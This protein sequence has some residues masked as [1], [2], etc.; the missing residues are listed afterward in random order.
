MALRQDFQ[1][2]LLRRHLESAL[3]FGLVSL[4]R[5]PGCANSLNFK[6]V[7][8]SDG[9]VFAV[10]CSDP[11]DV[12]RRKRLVAHLDELR[13]TKAVR[14]RLRFRFYRAMSDIVDGCGCLA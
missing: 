8:A 1:D 11:A 7:R 4:S 9:L 6:A 3:G 2:E 5:L 10:K 14:L 13:G 12:G